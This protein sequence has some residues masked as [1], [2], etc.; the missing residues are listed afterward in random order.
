M[1]KLWPDGRVESTRFLTFRNLRARF[2]PLIN[3]TSSRIRLAGI[4]V[5]KWLI[6][7]VLDVDRRG[8]EC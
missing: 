7:G 2:I 1:T 6:V 4:V 8:A 5:L 3:T